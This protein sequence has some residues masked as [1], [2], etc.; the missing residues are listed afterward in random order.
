MRLISLTLVLS[1]ALLTAA[2]VAPAAYAAS[3]PP[4]GAPPAMMAAQKAPVDQHDDTRVAVQLVVL[5]IAAGVVVGVGSCAY[6]LRKKL[7][8]VP[9]PKQGA[10]GHH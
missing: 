1:L 4:G 8:L 5:G 10:G 7:G 3:M 6:L 2:A 9:P